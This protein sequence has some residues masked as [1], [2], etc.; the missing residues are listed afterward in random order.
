MMK[1]PILFLLAL[2]ANGSHAAT[3]GPE[4]CRIIIPKPSEVAN[5][6]ASW[7]GACVNGYAD[8]EGE[9]VRKVDDREIGSFKGLMAQ[10]MM[11][12]G[13]EKAPGGG[14]FEG[15]YKNGYREGHGTWLSAKGDCYEGE[16]KYGW[17]DGAGVAEYALGG[18]VE[19]RW[20]RGKPAAT[21]KVIFAG[22]RTGTV[23]DIPPAEKPAG[24]AEK[25]NLRQVDMNSINHFAAKLALNGTVP[26]DKNYADMTPQQQQQFRRHYPVLH[27]DDTPPYPEKG[28]AQIFRWLSKA[29]GKLRIDGVLRAVVD[30]NAEGK[31][32][33]IR[34]FESPDPNLRELIKAI[35]SE[36]KFAPAVCSGKPCAMRFPFETRFTANEGG[37]P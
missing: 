7:S 24:E 10:G 5:E 34:V 8:G 25:F 28:T 37:G 11:A 21:N 16:W 18:R 14:Q 30:V 29:Q 26:F 4:N 19:G 23:A 12:K 1:K 17:R 36:Q 2:L 22:G 9:L 6:T 3:L 15:E 13:Y 31:A 32:T 27:P 35:M 33:S 20:T